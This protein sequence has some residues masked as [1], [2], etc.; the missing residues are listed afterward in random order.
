MV[1]RG[2]A[3]TLHVHLEGRVT[4][5]CYQYTPLT[6]H[7][8]LLTTYYLLPTTHYQLLTTHY[9]LP[10]T[11]YPLPTTHYSLL[12]TYYPLPT[13]HYPLPTTHCPLLATHCWLT[14]THYFLLASNENNS[15]LA[16]LAR[17]SQHSTSTPSDLM[18]G[19][20]TPCPGST[21]STGSDD[22]STS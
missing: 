6:T 21:A 12:T 4:S 11:H 8:S 2:G 18:A 1:G 13:T 9:L 20:S 19:A 7:H 3:V 22:Q 10:T 5:Q 16:P 17:S 14:T 15:P